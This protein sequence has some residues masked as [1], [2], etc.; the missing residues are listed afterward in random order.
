MEDFL[1][2]N[3]ISEDTISS[4]SEIDE[5]NEL[6]IIRPTKHNLRKSK[7][8]NY[9]ENSKKI[10]ESQSNLT[11]TEQ[12]IKKV[13]EIIIKSL[14]FY[15]KK[16]NEIA[17]I[18]TMLDPR[19]KDFSFLSNSEIQLEIKIKI[20]SLYENLKYKLNPNDDSFEI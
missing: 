19:Y 2:D 11:K 4:D 1:S 20:Q 10:Q 5:I 8:I 15:W 17:L 18:S 3:Y 7:K 14:N 13:L 16:P 12:I 9:N 6:L